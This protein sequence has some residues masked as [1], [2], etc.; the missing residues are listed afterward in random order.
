MQQMRWC[1]MLAAFTALGASAA[2]AGNA[3]IEVTTGERTYLGRSLAH[4]EDFCWLQE[5]D[6]RLM[7]IELADV[8][9]IR[10]VA[11]VFRSLSVDDARSRLARKLGRGYE[12]RNAGLHVV[13][14]APGRASLFVKLLDDVS[15]SFQSFFSRRNVSLEDVEF[16]LTAIVF[17]GR[18]RLQGIL[19]RRRHAVLAQRERLLQS[20]HESHCSLR[21][22]RTAGIPQAAGRQSH[23]ERPAASLSGGQYGFR[24]VPA[25]PK[26]GA[27]SFRRQPAAGHV[28]LRGELD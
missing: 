20:G 28:R 27:F 9:G 13:A 10:K 3:L 19:S 7:R 22:A 8:D 17:P 24:I 5:R 18:F 25:D 23:L 6:G 15:R 11:P 21:H 2:Q 16:P 1:A 4:D 12:V 26:A 14:A